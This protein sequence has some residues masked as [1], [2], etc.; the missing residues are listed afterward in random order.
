MVKIKKIYYIEQVIELTDLNE[1][2]IKEI[3]DEGLI[4]KREENNVRYFYDEDVERLQLIKRL[5]DELEINLAGID[6]IL[7]MRKKLIELQEN[8][9]DFIQIIKEELKKDKN[10]LMDKSPDDIMI[11]TQ[12]K[13]EPFKKE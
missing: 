12:G 10:Y 13:I 11:K 1:N 3:E 8:F 2:E 7:N 5:K 9:I 4:E 6:V